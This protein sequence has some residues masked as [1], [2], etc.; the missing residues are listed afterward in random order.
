MSG[1]DLGVCH[2]PDCEEPASWWK[3]GEKWYCSLDCLD[4]DRI[5]IPV[6][7]STD[8]DRTE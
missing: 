7:K 6:P 5:E 2:H 1:S 8:T 3:D 4:D